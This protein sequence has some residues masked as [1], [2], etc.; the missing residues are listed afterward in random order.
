MGTW[1]TS[2]TCTLAVPVLMSQVV[3]PG[4]AAPASRGLVQGVLGLR[5]SRL[6]IARPDRPVGQPSGHLAVAGQS[7]LGIVIAS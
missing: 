6:H 2:R 1:K 7:C 5:P 4:A 3:A